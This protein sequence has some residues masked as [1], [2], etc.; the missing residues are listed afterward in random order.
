LSLV[1][2]WKIPQEPGYAR[3]GAKA[4]REKM[5]QLQIEAKDGTD[6]EL[7]VH[8]SV[9]VETGSSMIRGHFRTLFERRTGSATYDLTS[10]CAL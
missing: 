10:T 8:L 5:E 7:R 4:R 9:N 1:K 2:D 6:I 3:N